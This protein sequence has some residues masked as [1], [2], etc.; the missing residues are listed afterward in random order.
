MHKLKLLLEAYANLQHGQNGGD[1][2]PQSCKGGTE[3]GCRNVWAIMYVLQVKK[4]KP[5]SSL[6]VFHH[7][8]LLCPFFDL[9][10]KEDH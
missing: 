7:L 8:G 5:T 2:C 3:V 10:K 1:C 9:S 4:E 6:C